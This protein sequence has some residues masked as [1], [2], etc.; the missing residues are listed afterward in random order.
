M[1]EKKVECQ[2][3]KSI[4]SLKEGLLPLI[5]FSSKEVAPLGNLIPF[6]PKKHGWGY[7][8]VFSLRKVLFF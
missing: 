1:I 7:H 6:S 2:I 3:S 5:I 4:S 8:F